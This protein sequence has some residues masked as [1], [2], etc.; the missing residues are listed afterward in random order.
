MIDVEGLFRRLAESKEV[1]YDSETSG[2]DWKRQHVVGHVVT[3]SGMDGDSFYLPFRHAAGGNI[4]GV[5]V[6]QTND[7]WRGDIHPLEK[8]LM[9]LLDR[10]DLKVIGHNLSFDLKFMYR[11][12][13]KFNAKYE[14]TI[15]NAPL[16]DE[17]QASF[18]LDFCCKNAGVPQKKTAIYEYILDK[19]PEVRSTPKQAMGHFWRLA[20]DDVEATGYAEGDGLSTWHLVQA[21]RSVIAR[22]GLTR[23]H[24]IESRLIP[25]L[26]RMST[27]G[28][29]IDLG[30][31]NEVKGIIE[32]RL[33]EAKR[34]LP[35]DFNSRAPTQVRALMEKGG[36]TDWPL[37]P[38]GQPSFPENWL[39]QNP[40]GA[41][42]VASR[43]YSNIL[44][45]F[46][47]P[48][49]DTH[50]WNGRVHP[51]YNQLRGDE[52]GTIT[53]RLSSSHPNLQQVHKRNKELGKLYR[54]I[55]IPD[56]GKVWA[57]VDYS[58]CEP[59]LL[60]YYS[61]AKILLEGY[62]SVPSVD[63][64]QAVATAANID[65][66]MGKRVNQTIITGGGKKVITDRYGV[67][68]EKVEEVW[69]AY[70][71]AMPELKPF[72]YKAADVMKSRGYVMSLLGRRSRLKDRNKAYV[73]VNRLLQMGNAE[74][75]KIKMVELDEYFASTGR[76]VDLLNNVHD[77]FD[78]QF[79]EKDR[80]H[81]NEALR[82]MTSFGEGDVITL[83]VPMK[84]DAG[85][86]AS[87]SE[88]TWGP[89]NA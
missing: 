31:L 34:A 29:K 24:D 3:F 78:L 33:E 86:G 87:W 6:P 42:I 12:G 74:V 49:L 70:F 5:E 36:F 11:L 56:G 14:D 59:R 9:R 39:S 16:I 25:V 32:G 52:F 13:Y 18:S 44:S 65:R 57:S 7:G 17:H 60:A 20:G 69:R 77:A 68:P 45:S 83:D 19:F 84:V 40:V 8:E 51:E 55:F 4:E 38:K 58:Q 62:R 67:P 22:D 15:I 85:E 88:A 27:R 26:A 30:R 53:G 1:V 28:V 73:A 21:Q 80:V 64:H 23:V 66:E 71:K 41:Q 81:Y 50:V 89:E 2:L 79:E 47:Q 43:K 63:A 37:T 82:I 75:L 76:T 46:I 35:E 10:P 72:Q 61:R 48:M 54:S